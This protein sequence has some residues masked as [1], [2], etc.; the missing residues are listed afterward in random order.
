MSTYDTIVIGGGLTGLFLTHRLHLSGKRVALFEARETLGGRYS[1]QSQSLPYSSSGLDFYPASNENLSLLEWIKSVSPLALNIEM[2]EHRPQL[3]DDARWKHFSGF[4]EV[5]FQSIGELAHFSATH[6]LTI[7]PGLE[8][9]VRAL[10]EQLPIEAE[11]RSE[12][13]GIKMADDTTCEI[14]INGDKSYRAERVVFTPHPALLNNLI[15]GETLNAKSRTRLAKMHAW[16]AVILELTHEKPLAEDNSIRIFTHS[17]KEFEP[18]VGRISGQTSKWM[19]LVPGERDT[20]VEFAG[21]CI[22]HIKRQ[23]KRAWPEAFE[24]KVPERIFIQ[25]NAFGQQTLKAK[26]PYR[27]PELPRLFLANHLLAMRAGELGALEVV[28]DV[29][30]ALFEGRL[31]AAPARESGTAEF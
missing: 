2:K 9:L 8:Q 21:Q 20:D 27:F 5:D 19:T 7:T 26:E 17:A 28:Q 31:S 16:T 18:V 14:T 29:E 24:G 13:T 12:L 25:P 23:L 22:R 30:A 15:E 6:D 10:V 3:Y 4:G 1:R 11:T